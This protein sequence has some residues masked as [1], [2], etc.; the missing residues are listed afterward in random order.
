LPWRIKLRA[1]APKTR[2][3]T[4]PIELVITGSNLLD[5]LRVFVVASSPASKSI[6]GIA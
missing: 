5:R 3:R 4:F 2:E 1:R 6:I